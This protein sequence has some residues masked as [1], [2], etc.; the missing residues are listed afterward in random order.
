MRRVGLALGGGVARG[1]AHVGVLSALEREGIPIDCVAGISAGAL[2]GALYCAGL[3]LAE[4]PNILA[5]FGWRTIARPA[6]S[7]QGLLSFDPLERWLLDRIGDVTFAGLR[8]PFA[9]VATELSTGQPVVLRQGRVAAAVRASCS[10]PGIIIP[11]AIDGRTLV[12]GGVAQNMP[13]AAVRGLGADYV[14]GVNL[15]GLGAARPGSLLST[16]WASLEHLLRGAGGGLSGADCLVSPELSG[17]SYVS[18]GRRLQAAAL[19]TRAAESQLPAIR[20][21]LTS[22]EPVTR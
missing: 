3:G 17:I 21:A 11:M 12:D 9:I 7:R 2:V 8:R 13:V 14:I 4:M 20:R 5:T 22:E 16:G 10:M 18:F 19:G 6:L 1:A 15:F